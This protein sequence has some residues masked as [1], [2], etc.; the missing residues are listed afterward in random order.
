MKKQRKTLSERRD[1]DMNHSGD[2]AEQMVRMSLDGVEFTA[3]ITGAAAKEIAI[4][5]VAALKNNDKN[6]KLKGRERMTSMLKSGN[7]LEVFSVRESDLKN[8]M[9]GAKQYGI[10]YCVLRN[11][12]NKADGLYDIM[13]KADDAP[14]IN[15]LVERFHLAV[16]DKGKVESEIVTEKDVKAPDIKATNLDAGDA[17]KLADK[18]LETAENKNIQGNQEKGSTNHPLANGG[19]PPKKRPSEITS[20]NRSKSARAIMSKPSVLKELQAITA[21][22]KKATKIKMRQRSQ[23]NGKMQFKKT[24]ERS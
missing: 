4:F 7:A 21:A 2:A 16:V 15:R 18:L 12:K 9:Q 1:R 13:V 19:T 17:G 24:K 10:V 23:I 5:L 14:R 11:T 8:F 3:K 20:G 6:I 22:M